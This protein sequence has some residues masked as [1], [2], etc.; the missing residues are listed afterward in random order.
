VVTSAAALP[1]P[2]TDGIDL[3]PDPLQAKTPAELVRVL[4]EYR[5]WAGEPPLRWIAGQSGNAAA[6]STICSALRAETLP[7]LGTVIAIV[8]GCDGS[9]EEQRRFVTAW[10]AIRLSQQGSTA[11]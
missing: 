10:R 9:E 8:A 1:L 5:L 4:R 11:A 2:D 6:A 3:K 7:R